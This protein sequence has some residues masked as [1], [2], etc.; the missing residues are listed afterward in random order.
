MIAV[1]GDMAVCV[2]LRGNVGD[3][4][5]IY[6]FQMNVWI[7]GSLTLLGEFF[8]KIKSV[9]RSFEQATFGSD[10]QNNLVRGE[11]A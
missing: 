2:D 1:L 9:F 3:F 6:S 8:S 10:P 11:T 7:C 5:F 4:W